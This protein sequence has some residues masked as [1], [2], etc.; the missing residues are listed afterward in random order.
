MV[1]RSVGRAGVRA[2]AKLAKRM[3][4]PKPVVRKPKPKPR[5]IVKKSPLV[6]KRTR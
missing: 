4:K 5:P 1:Y 6:R 3:V 2:G